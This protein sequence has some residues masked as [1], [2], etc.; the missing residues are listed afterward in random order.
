MEIIRSCVDSRYVFFGVLY[1]YTIYSKFVQ[2]V[3][4]RTGMRYLKCID[5][6]YDNIKPAKK[7][8]HCSGSVGESALIRIVHSNL[9]IYAHM[10]FLIGMLL[11]IML[12]TKCVVQSCINSKSIQRSIVIL[13]DEV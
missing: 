1:C 7:V 13:P 3:R 4:K 6:V 5:Q 11:Y 12:Y 10:Q 9:A 2:I 8:K